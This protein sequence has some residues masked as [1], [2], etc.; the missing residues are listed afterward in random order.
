MPEISIIVPVYN[1]EK[2]IN[3][4]VDSIL[5]QTF[6]N[7]ELILIDDG[8]TDHSGIICDRYA[9]LD[10]KICVI[11]KENGGVSTA[12]NIGLEHINGKYVAFCDSDDYWKEDWLEQLYDSMQKNDADCV[13][14]CFIEVDECGKLLKTVS[15]KCNEYV[16]QTEQSI[17]DFLTTEQ[18]TGKIGWEI[19]TRLFIT[20]II[21]MQHIRFCENCENFAEDL[22]FVLEYSLFCHRICSVDIYGYCYVQREGSMMHKN[23]E[24]IKLN[25]MNEVSRQF[26]KRFFNVF[27]DKSLKKQFPILHFLIMN[28]QY[29]KKASIDKCERF[30]EEIKEIINIEWYR[31]YTLRILFCKSKLKKIFGT[32]NALRIIFFSMLCVCKTIELFCSQHMLF[33]QN[34]RGEE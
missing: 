20:D 12:R 23:A 7:F 4:C 17:I 25:A 19:C 1:A 13:S 18:L 33:Y 16:L 34:T 10:D 29:R 21:Q 30:F 27:T 2:Y 31:Q 11:H 28:N 5:C 22:C 9:E 6:K 32:Y 15:Y 8:S 26:G 24:N 14:G 3:K